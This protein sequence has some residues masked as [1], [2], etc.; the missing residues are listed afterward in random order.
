MHVMNM[1]FAKSVKS[2]IFPC[3]CVC[4]CSNCG[5][6]APGISANIA[7]LCSA[8]VPFHFD[9]PTSSNRQNQ[10]KYRHNLSDIIIFEIT[11]A[12]SKIA[13][14]NTRKTQHNGMQWKMKK[15][16]E[17]RGKRER[18]RKP[19]KLPF[20]NSFLWQCFYC[21]RCVWNHFHYYLLCRTSRQKPS[22]TTPPPTSTKSYS[23]N[24][25]RKRQQEP[26]V[27][28]S[29]SHACALDDLFELSIRWEYS[30]CR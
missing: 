14:Q 20:S 13:I 15:A 6:C 18:V 29:S 2:F 3:F 10:K 26:K 23:S 28:L 17:A 19:V 30:K 1:A 22:T 11:F 5:V 21:E 7:C 4:G 16:C 12:K 8:S 27:K 9:N 24:E 25:K